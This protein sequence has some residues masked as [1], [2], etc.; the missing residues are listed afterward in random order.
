M[1]G[2]HAVNELSDAPSS[3][4]TLGPEHP[5]ANRTRF[6][7]SRLLL[8]IPGLTEALALGEAALAAHYTVLGWDHR[9]D[10]GPKKRAS[11]QMCLHRPVPNSYGFLF[12]F[13]D[14]ALRLHAA[15]RAYVANIHET[16]CDERAFLGVHWSIT[17]GTS[18]DGK[19]A[20][21]AY[22][23]WAAPWVLA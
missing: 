18:N 21:V 15:H 9:T 11:G 14:S 13:L 16:G 7:L 1:N 20:Q 23:G 19:S 10:T 17:A 2:Q 3:E 5:D 8:L 4:K 12:V 6:N 22:H